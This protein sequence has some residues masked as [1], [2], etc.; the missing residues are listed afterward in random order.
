MSKKDIRCKTIGHRKRALTR[1]YMILQRL[2]NTDRN[3][4]KCY[5]NITFD[6]DKEEFINWF[7]ANDF[8]R[9]SVDRIDNSKGYSIDN[10]Q[11]ISIEE[12]IRKDKVKAK[13]GYCVCYKCKLQK[14]L[15]EMCKDSSRKNGRTTLCV[16]CERERG[17]EKYKRLYKKGKG[18]NGDI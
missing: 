7:M 13:N 2:N 6:L 14:P 9:C 3:K 5:K 1:Y 11:L 15:I 16:E 10:I 18:C 8:E 12:N 4:N 17:R